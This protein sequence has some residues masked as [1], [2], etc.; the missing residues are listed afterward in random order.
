MIETS[1]QVSQSPI[2]DTEHD[3]HKKSGSSFGLRAA[4]FI[5][6]LA[7]LVLASMLYQENST[8]TDTRTQLAQATDEGT[9]IKADLDKANIQVAGMQ[10]QLSAAT[11]KSA[12]IQ[13]Q[14][15]KAQAQNADL[16]AQLGKDRS[17][18][19]DMKA[20]LDT[21][22]E[23]LSEAQAQISQASDGSALLRKQLDAAKSQIADLQNQQARAQVKGD[24]GAA[25]A[26]APTAAMPVAAT[27]EKSFW[28][29]DFTLHIRNTSPGPLNVTIAVAGSQGQAPV[30]AKIE[31]GSIFD[32]K[33][34][35][36]GANVVLTSDGFSPVNLTVH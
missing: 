32:L 14:L 23:R 7:S 22:K 12:D 34:L 19:S 18:A 27:F 35:A 1:P 6:A 25:Q 26:S 4:C 33:K 11:A 13:A 28:T 9:Q 31:G 10:S 15:A 3:E 5:L 21:A 24:S 17:Q 20:Q 2:H 16:Q 8:V 30:S 36:S 29:G